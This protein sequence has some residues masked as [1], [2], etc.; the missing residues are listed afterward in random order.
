VGEAGLVGSSDGAV[1]AI[2]RR[3]DDSPQGSGRSSS[4]QRLSGVGGRR[5]DGVELLERQSVDRVR[6][7][8]GCEC[9]RASD[10]G[11]D[12]QS[13]LVAEAGDDRACRQTDDEER[14]E[15]RASAA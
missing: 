4:G 5:R 1:N 8:D 13:A 9:D 10:V 11:D 3:V 7:R 14:Q 15:L 12:E 2:S 6:G